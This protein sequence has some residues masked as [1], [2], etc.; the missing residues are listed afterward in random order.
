MIV[1]AITSIIQTV[2]KFIDDTAE[3]C[4]TAKYKFSSS[5]SFC[6][7]V[8]KATQNIMC[9]LHETWKNN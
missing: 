2:I 8:S 4:Q 1:Q 9:G 3:E 6:V 7:F 5:G